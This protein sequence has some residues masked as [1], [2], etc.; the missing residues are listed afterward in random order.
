M[1][2]REC[3]NVKNESAEINNLTLPPPK[4]GIFSITMGQNTMDQASS[5]S[6]PPLALGFR[7]FGKKSFWRYTFGARNQ[8]ECHG[9]KLMF[10][11]SASMDQQD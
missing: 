7:R 8:R 11:R 3:R 4:S 2:K 6:N 5:P 1:L 9:D 10:L